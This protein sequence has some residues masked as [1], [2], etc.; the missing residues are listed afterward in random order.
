[1][2]DTRHDLDLLALQ[3]ARD[4]LVDVADN[5]PESSDLRSIAAMLHQA[6]AIKQAAHAVMIGLQTC[7]GGLIRQ[8]EAAIAA[9]QAA[10]GE[11][12]F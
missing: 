1:M 5:P 10:Q 2:P 9:A 7:M 8:R 4:L 6:T 11:M 12:S 3:C